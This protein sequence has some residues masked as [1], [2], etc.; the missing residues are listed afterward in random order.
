MYERVAFLEGPAVHPRANIAAHGGAERFPQ[1]RARARVVLV[2]LQI[3]AHP[4]QERV[5]PGPV[6]YILPVLL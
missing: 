3:R 1:I 5:V 4:P 2:A 6:Q